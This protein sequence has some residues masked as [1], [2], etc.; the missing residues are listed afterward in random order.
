VLTYSVRSGSVSVMRGAADQSP[1]LV[2]RIGHGQTGRIH[3]GEWIIEQ[4]STIHRARNDGRTPVVILLA[5]LF[6]SGSP[7]SLP[8]N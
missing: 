1:K 8:V 3:P 5:T 6:S 2:R 4:P 7:P